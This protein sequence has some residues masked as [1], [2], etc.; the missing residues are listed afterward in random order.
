MSHGQIIKLA[1]FLFILPFSACDLPVVPDVAKPGIS[2]DEAAGF[3]VDKT[4]CNVPCTIAVS[5]TSSTSAVAFHW[6]FGRFPGDTSS[7]EDP[8]P[9]LYE[10]PGNYFIKLWV[11]CENGEASSVVSVPISIIDPTVP[12]NA[13]FALENNNCFSLCA[14]SFVNQSTNFDSCAWFVDGVLYS[15]QTNPPPWQDCGEMI[16]VPVELKVFNGT[17]RDS[18][19]QALNVLVYRFENVVNGGGAGMKIFQ[20]EDDS[21]LVAGQKGSGGALFIHRAHPDGSSFAGFPKTVSFNGLKVADVIRLSSD[22][23]HFALLGTATNPSN[24]SRMV[25]YLFDLDGESVNGDPVFFP[26]D[27][28]TANLHIVAQRIRQVPGGKLMALG[29]TF[30]Q[31]TGKKGFLLKAFNVAFS[32][33]QPPLLEPSTGTD[34][35]LASDMAVSGSSLLV[36]GSMNSTTGVLF[37]FTVNIAGDPAESSPFLNPVSGLTIIHS[38]ALSA[39]EAQLYF[40]GW[41]LSSNG[42]VG[43]LP[44][45]GLGVPVLS[46]ILF[47]KGK[48]SAI[49]VSEDEK[50]LLLSGWVDGVGGISNAAMMVLNPGLQAQV[51]LKQFGDLIDQHSFLAGINTSDCGFALG[52]SPNAAFSGLFLVKTDQDGDVE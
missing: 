30:N 12:P 15:T 17:L 34:N 31:A 28:Q 33:F 26:E 46:Q 29:N 7:A 19:T 1:V 52:G 3:E 44:A 40:A 42:L 2:C 5:N 43:K 24:K 50:S 22:P 32:S 48:V 18:I 39:G 41:D 14:V 10:E 45:T 13:L 9:V 47:P 6:D 21:Y 51:A 36:G 37:R 4:T 35:Y 16:N 38:L 23:N 25:Y 27:A 8:D 49:D 11:E 20:L